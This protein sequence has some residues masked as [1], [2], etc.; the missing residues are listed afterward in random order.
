MIFYFLFQVIKINKKLIDILFVKRIIKLN[1]FKMI[2]LK[3]INYS[4]RIFFFIFK[5]FINI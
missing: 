5:L 1:I 2:E 3:F 4:F